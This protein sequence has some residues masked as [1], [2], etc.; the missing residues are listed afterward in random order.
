MPTRSLTVPTSVPERTRGVIARLGA[1]AVR[2]TPKRAMIGMTFAIFRN[3]PFG[4]TLGYRK[5][6][7]RWRDRLIADLV[8]HLHL[9]FI[10]TRR[11]CL[12]RQNLFN[13]HLVRR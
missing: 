7:G 12:Q 13:R 10:L 5:H 8:R 1:G 9:D 11:D 3:T 6:G 2:A 4:L